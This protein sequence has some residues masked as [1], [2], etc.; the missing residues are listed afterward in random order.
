MSRYKIWDKKSDIITPIGEVLTPMQWIERYPVSN[1]LPTVCG[2]GVI[3]GSF[4]AIYDEMINMYIK[5]GCDFS[6]CITEQ[7]HLNKIE[8]FEDNLNKPN[9]DV[10]TEERTASA[11]EALVL[12]NMEDE[13]VV[14]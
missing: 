14:E 10:T 6:E 1:I 11:L 3:N 9:D 4:F 5:Q 12:L 13:T 2:G 8:E 7:D